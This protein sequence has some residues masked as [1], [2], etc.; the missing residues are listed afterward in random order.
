MA[1]DPVKHPDPIKEKDR[2]SDSLGSHTELEHADQVSDTPSGSGQEPDRFQASAK[3]ANPLAGL[4]TERLGKLGVEYAHK[5]GLTDEEHIRAFRLGAMVAGHENKHDTIEGLT[6][7][8]RE[9]I[10]RETT[11]KWSNPSMLYWVIVSKS[12]QLPSYGSSCR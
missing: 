12:P 7:A 5:V 9:A 8:E 6:D 10:D 11:H 4:S 2:R 1:S 3:L